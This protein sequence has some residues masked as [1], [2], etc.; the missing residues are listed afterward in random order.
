M[1]QVVYIE[2]LDRDNKAVEKLKISMKSGFGEGSFFLSAALPSDNYLLRAYTNW[3]KNS[4]PDF[5][6]HKMISVVNPFTDPE[7]KVIVPQLE[8][9]LLPEGGNLVNG[10]TSKV[11]FK[12]S[13]HTGEGIDFLG[14]LLDDTNDTV[15]HFK[16]LKFGIGNF[17]F[18]PSKTKKYRVSI[19][20]KGF[21]VSTWVMPVVQ[22]SGYVVRVSELSGTVSLDLT[23]AGEGSNEDIT[24]FTHTR[25]TTPRTFTKRMSDQ[26]VHFE[27]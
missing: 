22:S 27:F 4:D 25:N 8:V 18:T 13:S 21:P 17:E 10:L 3:M 26:K 9:S 1:S 19:K 11:G 12:V 24:L 5:Y 20:A 23:F 7:L 14:S 2:L 6:F 15:L 16:P